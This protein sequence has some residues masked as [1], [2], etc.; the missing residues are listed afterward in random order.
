M[1][2]DKQEI[3]KAIC[4]RLV[5]GQSLRRILREGGDEGFPKLSTFY[6]WLDEDS[7]LGRS[8]T[9]QYTAARVRQADTFADMLQD[10][11]EDGTNDYMAAKGDKAYEVNGEAIARSKLRIETL[12][13]TAAKQRP[14][15][16]GERLDIESKTEIEVKHTLE[17]PKLIELA[18]ALRNAPL[19][20]PSV[21]EAEYTEVPP[22]DFGDL[23]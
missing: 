4:V 2:V 3:M 11:A 16:Y 10:I 7:D 17:Q 12:K 1:S 15:K 21:A 19:A 6:D 8:L 23:L 20:L 13:W 9:E 22:D 5:E 14:R 18:N